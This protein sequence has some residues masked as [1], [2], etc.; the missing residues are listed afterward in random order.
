MT[1]RLTA[2]F[3]AILIISIFTV[4]LVSGSYYYIQLNSKPVGP[5]PPS[6][7]PAGFFVSNLTVSPSE[8]IINQPVVV[9]VNVQNVG[10]QI[11]N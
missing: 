10:E 5:S 6:L 9:S 3:K 4:G 1:L 11:G 2:T 7:K 8:A